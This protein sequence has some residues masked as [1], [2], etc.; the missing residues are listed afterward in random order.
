MTTKTL[1]AKTAAFADCGWIDAS[2][3][4]FECWTLLPP[5]APSMGGV[6]TEFGDWAVLDRG[7][8]ISRHATRDEAMLASELHQAAPEVARGNADTTAARRRAERLARL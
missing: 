7:K 2:C 5:D 4:A 1:P 8:I 6:T 3:P